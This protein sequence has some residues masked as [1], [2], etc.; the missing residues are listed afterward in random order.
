MSSRLRN[1]GCMHMHTCACARTHTKTTT[2]C[3]T[4]NSSFSILTT[5]WNYV[6]PTALHETLIASLK[7]NKLKKKQSPNTSEEASN[8]NSRHSR[9]LI[10][11]IS[12]SLP[13]PWYRLALD[14]SLHMI[15]LTI[16]TRRTNKL[17]WTLQS[18]TRTGAQCEIHNTT[19][20]LP[21]QNTK[22]LLWWK[23]SE[24][25]SWCILNESSL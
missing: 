8:E 17:R 11:H 1:S 16:G 18:C 24:F 20:D 2:T 6:N 22:A 3:E 21:L 15:K 25:I 19:D 4:L 23:F 9:Q 10:S 13:I 12:D 14:F 7:I 5:S